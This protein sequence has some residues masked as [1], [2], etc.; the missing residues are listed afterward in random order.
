MAITA[1]QVIA[2]RAPEFSSD[3][4]LPDLITMA[5]GFVGEV[6]FGSKRDYA[7]AMLVCHWLTL[8]ARASASSG[9]SAPSGP[10][11]SLKE[12]DLSASFAAAAPGSAGGSS[13]DAF[14]AATPWGVEFANVRAG[15]ILGARNSA[16]PSLLP[17]SLPAGC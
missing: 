4:R 9:G 10:V 8:S 3:E 1:A 15:V 7:V 16:V 14:L 12:G 11:T 6:I 13:M 5:E 17:I 2:L